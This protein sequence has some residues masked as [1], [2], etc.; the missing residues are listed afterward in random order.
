MK[1]NYVALNSCKYSKRNVVSVC[2]F[3]IL[4]Y[5]FYPEGSSTNRPFM[6]SAYVISE[7]EITTNALSRNFIIISLHSMKHF[8]FTNKR[9]E[10]FDHSLNS[11]GNY[12]CLL[13]KSIWIVDFEKNT[14]STGK[15]THHFEMQIKW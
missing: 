7:V 6:T 9:F 8:S 2:S 3:W 5:I 13:L 11:N 4:A 1:F 12:R 10:T 14:R 15:A